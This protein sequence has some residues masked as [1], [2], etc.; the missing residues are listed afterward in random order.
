MRLG[1]AGGMG[2]TET[3]LMDRELSLI[4]K[5]HTATKKKYRKGELQI[6]M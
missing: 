4:A 2:I 5:W 3:T 1:W 6:N